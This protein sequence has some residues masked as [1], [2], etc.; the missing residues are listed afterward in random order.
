M[1][2][3]NAVNKVNKHVTDSFQIIPSALLVSKMCIDRC[4]PC[5]AC[6]L[7][8]VSKRYVKSCFRVL[9]L[10]AE[11]QIYYVARMLLLIQAHHEVLRLNV[12]MQESAFVKDFNS[13]N[14]LDAHH[15]SGPH[16]K[17]FI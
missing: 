10:F 5:S 12:S 15:A 4:V 2:W 1:P 11:S 8:F 16:I 7:F 13:V 6:Q 3:Q 17:P 9:P 14:H